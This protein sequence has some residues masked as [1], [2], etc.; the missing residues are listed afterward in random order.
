LNP[1]TTRGAKKNIIDGK[2]QAD[3]SG[4]GGLLGGALPGSSSTGVGVAAV[5]KDDRGPAILKMPP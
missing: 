4:I 2:V 3:G 1:D 5:E